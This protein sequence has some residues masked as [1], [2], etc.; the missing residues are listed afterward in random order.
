MARSGRPIELAGFG[1]ESKNAASGTEE[2]VREFNNGLVHSHSP[3]A[4][5]IGS[6][7]VIGR[8]QVLET[9]PEH[10]SPIQAEL[11]GS[12]SKECRL[13]SSRFDHH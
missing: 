4:D 6:W 12:V 3:D 7:Q 2:A 5:Q 13:S 8:D 10:L 1:S 11:A 9:G